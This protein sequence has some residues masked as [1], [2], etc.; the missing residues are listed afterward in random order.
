M[1]PTSI[2]INSIDGNKVEFTIN[3]EGFENNI[4]DRLVVASIDDT[5]DLDTG[6]VQEEDQYEQETH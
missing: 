4:L 6:T 3:Y 1:Q 2:T 5:V